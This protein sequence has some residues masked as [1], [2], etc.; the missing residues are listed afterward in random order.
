VSHSSGTKTSEILPME[1]VLISIWKCI[2]WFV[3]AK[4]NITKKLLLTDARRQNNFL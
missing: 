4:V 3:D 1:K 2:K